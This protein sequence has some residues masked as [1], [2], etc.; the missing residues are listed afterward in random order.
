VLPLPDGVAPEAPANGPFRV[1]GVFT[2]REVRVREIEALV[3]A[4]GLEAVRRALP[5]AVVQEIDT[6]M[7]TGA[8]R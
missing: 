6:T 4:G 5:D 3:G 1:I 2:K 7:Q 8:K